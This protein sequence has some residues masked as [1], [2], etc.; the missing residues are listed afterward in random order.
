VKGCFLLLYWL[1]F[2]YF[3]S[4]TLLTRE[5]A[6]RRTAP[7]ILLLGAIFVWLAIGL[8]Y[9]VGADWRAYEFLY[10]FAGY[11]G[12][13][14]ILEFGDPGYQLL[15]W[16]LQQI[17]AEIWVLNLICGL[18]FTWGLYRFASILPD[19]WLAFVVAVPYLII[20]VAM[21]YTRQAVAIG[22]LMA[23]LAALKQSGSIMRF[24]VYVAVA[25]LF[26]KTAVMILPLVIFAG[27]RN[28]LLNA[29][30]GIAGC[31]L[32]YDLFLANSID[33]LVRNY[34]EAKYSSQGAGIRV[35]M[36]FF[37]A[38]IFLLF[39]N[40]L[41][42]DPDEAEYW[43]YFSLASLVMPLL[44]V[45]LPSSTAVDRISLYLIPLQIAVLPRVQYLFKTQAFGRAVVVFYAGAVM[46]IWLNFAVHARY[47]V[48]YKI[49]PRLLG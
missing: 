22:I 26:H 21:G 36:N 20:V 19:P 11:S 13:G 38:V 8:R 30:A 40:R 45:L 7:A 31:V 5:T 15:N 16:A 4:G 23:G 32:L 44:L 2:A 9:K 34:V 28:K 24:A 35:A 27:Q 18:I 43:R 47:W 14:R 1:L 42:F 49:Y 48:P 46:F 39:K 33:D 25:A 29:I 10:S 3:A 37:P 12:L 41:R 6:G 17:G